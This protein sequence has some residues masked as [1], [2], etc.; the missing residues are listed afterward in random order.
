[1]PSPNA[2]IDVSLTITDAPPGQ[3]QT[4]DRKYDYTFNPDRVHVTEGN[5]EIVYRLEGKHHDRFEMSDIFTT[6]ARSQ[7]SGVEVIEGGN[8][9]RVLHANT[10]KQ[11]TVVLVVVKD[12]EKQ[13][14]VGLDPQ[15]TNDP[16]P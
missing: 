7:F 15:V 8:A 13:Q 10:V 4:S 9:I 3:G 1:V 6:D 2:I 12:R 11:L 14:S 5:T 16:T